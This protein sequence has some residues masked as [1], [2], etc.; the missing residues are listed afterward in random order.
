[1]IEDYGQLAM[2][3]VL[4]R[5]KHISPF[6]WMFVGVCLLALPCWGKSRTDDG[7]TIIR[8]Y[9]STAAVQ[10]GGG[11]GKVQTGT[12]VVFA[13]QRGRQWIEIDATQKDTFLGQD[14]WTKQTVR[15]AKAPWPLNAAAPCYYEKVDSVNGRIHTTS[16]NATVI[17]G[18]NLDSG[19]LMITVDGPV[20]TT[21]FFAAAAKR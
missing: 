9:N 11:R 10:I 7:K 2:K 1:M 19:N 18:G 3:F 12:A 4:A 17:A 5:A 21:F 15:V 8:K 13:D 14:N 16:M 20:F 6:T